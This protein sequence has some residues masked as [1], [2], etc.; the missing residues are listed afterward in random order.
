MQDAE[1]I[2]KVA[3]P[4]F[5][6]EEKLQQPTENQSRALI[7]CAVKKKVF[8][9]FY[10]GCLQN[11]I[12]LPKEADALMTSFA[13][14]KQKQIESAKLLVDIQEKSKIGLLF[15]KTFRPFKYI[16][17]DIDILVQNEKD[18]NI[19]INAI[20]KEGYLSLKI[21][22]PEVS[23]RKLEDGTYVDLDVHK[24]LAVG[25]LELFNVEQLWQNQ[26]FEEFELSAGYK[27]LKLSEDY[28]VVREAAYSL[29]KD[30]NLSI[31]G[32][33][34][35]LNALLN[36]NLEVIEEI[37]VKNNFVFHLNLYLAL[38]YTL[39]VKFYGAEAKE[40]LKSYL[41][42]NSASLLPLC[43]NLKV[44]YPYPFTVITWAYLSKAIGEIS[45]SRNVQV[46]PQIMKQP[47]SKGISV[48]LDTVRERIF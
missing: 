42:E 9:M 37:S 21:G 33:Y 2:L 18:Y 20:Q 14:R 5:I 8:P 38:V 19:L 1:F 36:R 3:N 12:S 46:I 17:D 31:A 28:E 35:G 26:A 45:H 32:F 29:L 30:F 47:A 6:Q 4:Y 22:T 39:A 10:D 40:R 25:S 16:P 44:P 24:R 34:L 23:F 41:P 15:F 13:L 7:K 27:A 48:I 43:R 11:N